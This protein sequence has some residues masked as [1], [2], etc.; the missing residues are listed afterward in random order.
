MAQQQR[1]AAQAMLQRLMGTDPLLGLPPAGVSLD[2]MLAL[3]A[4]ELAAA[5]KAAEERSPLLKGASASLQAAEAARGLALSGWLPDLMVQG[6]VTADQAGNEQ[7]G[8][9]LALSLPW[10]WYPK[11]AGEAGAA[12]AAEDKACADLQGARL[13]LREQ[14]AAAVGDLNAAAESLRTAWTRTYP[15]AARGLELA[16]SG[17]RTTALGSSEILMAVQDYRTTEEGLA[18]LIAQWGEAQARLLML[19]AAPLGAADPDQG[20]RP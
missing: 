7:S 17:F 3:P 1:K 20:A 14:V 5:L 9:M 18:G 16:R 10:L 8:A 6:S 15:Q 13:A 4:P 19:T 12:A 11:Q 2:A